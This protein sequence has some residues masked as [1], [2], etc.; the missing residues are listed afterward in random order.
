MI[1]EDRTWMPQ[2]DDDEPGW[3]FGL[4]VLSGFFAAFSCI[5]IATYTMMR[6]WELEQY[7]QGYSYGAKKGSTAMPMVPKV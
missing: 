5:S 3:S 1:G 4:A 6:E 7:K 2:P